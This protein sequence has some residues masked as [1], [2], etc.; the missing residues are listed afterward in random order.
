[1]PIRPLSPAL[2]A[3]KSHAVP[4]FEGSGAGT[5]VTLTGTAGKKLHVS[6]LMTRTAASLLHATDGNDVTLASY[7]FT[8]A[9]LA[10]VL[11]DPAKT[12]ALTTALV[13]DASKSQ[14]KVFVDFKREL[15]TYPVSVTAVKAGDVYV[16]MWKALQVPTSSPPTAQS[17]AVEKQ[18]KADLRTAVGSLLHGPEDKLLWLHWDNRDDTNLDAVVAFNAKTGTV[19]LMKSLPAI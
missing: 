8:P 4:P 10:K 13:L 18:A 15:A 2:R 3:A 9:A 7:R 1:M 14:D 17:T 6:A 11:A 19:R 12:T 5:A 16:K